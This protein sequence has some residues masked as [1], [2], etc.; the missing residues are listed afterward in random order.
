[1][2]KSIMTYSR[3]YSP[4]GDRQL[5]SHL[6]QNRASGASEL[7]VVC[8]YQLGCSERVCVDLT[9]FP[10]GSVELVFCAD[11][12]PSGGQRLDSKFSAF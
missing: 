2:A 3:N 11:L 6:G 7:P 8:G 10:V 4:A 1:M 5:I 12:C 9:S